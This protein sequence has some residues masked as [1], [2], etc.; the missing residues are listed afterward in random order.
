MKRHHVR[1]REL[2]LVIAALVAA[3]VLALG[4]YL[5]QG[6]AYRGMGIDPEY[7][8]TLQVS[9]ADSKRQ[10]EG[11]E[12][13]LDVSQA[14]NE[15]DRA[16]LEIV[17][18]EIAAQKSQVRDLEENLRFYQ[19]L[20]APEDIVRGLVLRPMELVAAEGDNRYA[21]RIVVQQEARKHSLLKGKLSV[22]VV[23]SADGGE[24]SL[25]LSALSKEVEAE[26]VALR[27][28]YFQVFEGELL[29]PPGFQPRLIIMEASVTAP[30]KAKVQDQFP[31]SVQERFS[32]VGK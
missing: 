7:H 18:R 9:L 27:F 28:R 32:Y 31:W 30:A 22:K 21:F 8:K 12:Q 29:L 6:A 5:G 2:Q 17:R 25:A 23:G 15:I 13:T 14:R 10:L 3:A 16:A 26:T 19:G 20:M 11:L 4:F 24:L 1:R